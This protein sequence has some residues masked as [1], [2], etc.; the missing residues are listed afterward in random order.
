[1]PLVEPKDIQAAVT[2]LLAAIA[3][4]ITL[5][6]ND[7]NF[8]KV[9]A[10]EQAIQRLLKEGNDA[11]SLQDIMELLQMFLLSVSNSDWSQIDKQKTEKIDVALK[12]FIGVFTPIDFAFPSLAERIQRAATAAATADPFLSFISLPTDQAGLGGSF[13]KNHSFFGKTFGNENNEELFVKALQNHVNNPEIPG[14]SNPAV[15]KF[16]AR[17]DAMQV[18]KLGHAMDLLT[19]Q[20]IGLANCLGGKNNPDQAE[21]VEMEIQIFLST[22]WVLFPEQDE[23]KKRNIETALNEFIAELLSQDMRPSASASL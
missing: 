5:S 13:P 18:A 9:G 7:Q 1:M 14:A 23:Q 6:P 8:F 11:A 19:L 2:K 22:L 3:T 12:E 20:A 10:I 15:I 21:Q 16:I 17:I 4:Q